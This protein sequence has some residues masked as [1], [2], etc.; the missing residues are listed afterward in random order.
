[1]TITPEDLRPGDLMFGPIG[2]LVPGVLPVGAGQLLLAPRKDRLTWRRWWKV[3]HAGVIVSAGQGVITAPRLVQ[4]MPGGAEEI[5]LR[6]DL[7]WTDRHVYIRPAYPAD[8][9]Q[10]MA[11]EFAAAAARGYVDTPYGFLTL[12]RTGRQAS[13]PWPRWCDRG[14]YRR[15]GVRP[16]RDDLLTA[17]GSGPGRC[18]F[19]RVR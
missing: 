15:A 7:H 6:M 11:G 14:A 19:P 17:G 4:A 8:V 5:D 13:H 2:G 16:R 9:Q 3:R 18:R 1:M 10:G 12:R